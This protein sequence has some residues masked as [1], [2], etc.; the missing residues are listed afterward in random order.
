ML[1]VSNFVTRRMVGQRKGRFMIRDTITQIEARLRNSD[2]LNDQA[3]QDLLSLL[4]TLKAEVT[5]LSHTD[6]ERLRRLPAMRKPP[7]MPR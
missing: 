4:A 6:S 5:Q 7:P 3:R 2:S 1:V